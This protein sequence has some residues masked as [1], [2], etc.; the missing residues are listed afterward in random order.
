MQATKRS[1]KCRFLSLV[2]L[3]FDLTFR[4]VRVRDQT[5]LLCEFSTNPF[6][7]SVDISYTNKCSTVAEMGYRLAPIDMGQKLGAWAP[8]LG[9]GVLGHHVTRGLGRGCA[10]VASGICTVWHLDPSRRLAT[11][12]MAENWGMGC[13]LFSGSWVPIYH[14]VAWAEAYVHPCQVAS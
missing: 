12:D 1:R 10:F 4:L 5:C 11:I 3:T 8:F 13:A 14:S 2:T 9:G 7:C 6:S